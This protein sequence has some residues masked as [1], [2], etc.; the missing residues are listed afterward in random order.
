M[1][2]VMVVD[3]SSTQRSILKSHLESSFEDCDVILCES[4]EAALHELYRAVPDIVILDVEM[5]GLSG[6][7][8]CRAMRGYMQDHWVPIIYLTARTSEDSLIEGLEAGGDT[9]LTKPVNESVLKAI[10]TAMLRISDVQQELIK[11]NKKLDEIAYFDVLTQVMNRRGY[12]DIYHRLWD[13]H[14]RRHLSLSVLLMDIDHFKLYNDN[15]G[16][17]QGD[18]CLRDVA[19]AIKKALLRPVDVVARYGG[20]EFIVLLPDTDEQGAL[21][22]ANRILQALNDAALS[23]DFSPV[24]KRVSVSIGVAHSGDVS[25]CQMQP[26]D[27]VARADKGLYLAKENGRNQVACANIK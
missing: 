10:V 24:S 5:K 25:K 20:E 8:T 11:A 18:Q 1:H 15:Y 3:D 12:E 19:Q 4:G 14:K 6:F 13:D 23:H 17:I 27:L 16:H 26:D 21:N 2:S 7:E 9:Y 22:V